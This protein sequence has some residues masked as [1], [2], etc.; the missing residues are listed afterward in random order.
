MNIIEKAIRA[1][2]ERQ[3]AEH[4][5]E[6]GRPV[7]VDSASPGPA[8]A[9]KTT[10]SGPVPE[11]GQRDPPPAEPRSGVGRQ[12]AGRIRFTD[13]WSSG[14]LPVEPSDHG[15]LL[16]MRHLKRAVLQGAFGPAAESGTNLVAITSALPG[17]GKTFL[18]AGLAQAL[19][20]ERDR[21][22][23]LIDADDARASITRAVGLHGQRGLFDCLHEQVPDLGSATHATDL[24]GLQFVPAGMNY[25]DSLEMLTSRHAHELFARLSAE[26]PAR[27]IVIDCPP[28]LGTPNS[29]ALAALAGQVIVVVEAGST[30]GAALGQALELLNRQKPIGLVLNKVPRS[31]LLKSAGGSYYYYYGPNQP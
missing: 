27:V 7:A 31:R 10:A 11:A 2:A 29:A 23:L 8:V 12:P 4:P 19:T 6:R 5:E 21:T 22:A 1:R 14:F 25:P 13:L 9:P 16:E 20:L 17:A 18:S 28:L 15:V 26:D 3:G 30:N 24:P